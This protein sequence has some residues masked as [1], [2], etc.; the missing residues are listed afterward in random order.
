VRKLICQYHL[1]ENICFLG[2][3]D[4][5]EM[6]EQYL[7]ANVFVLPS[8]IENSPNSLG[9]AMI[10]GTPVVVSDVGGVKNMIRHMEEGYIY[11]HDAPYMIAY[12]VEKYFEMKESAEQMTNRA[13]EHAAE[14][15]H[16]KKNIDDL[17]KIYEELQ[18]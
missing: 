5:K 7:R 4:E 17:I 2:T 10:L 16:V 11:Q 13:R 8:A 3:L 1:E 6:C 18:K 9:E 15:F 12:Y 14:I